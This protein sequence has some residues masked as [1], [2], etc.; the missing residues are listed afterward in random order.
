MK[1][2]GFTIIELL[3]VIFIITILI[4]L[5]IPSISKVKRLTLDLKQKAEF[6]NIE[7]GVATWSH[8]HDLE[9]PESN[10][11]FGNSYATVG[12]QKLAEALL[13]RDLHGFDD[14][15]T[16]NAGQD[17]NDGVAYTGIDY[18]NREIAYLDVDNFHAYQLAQIYDMSIFASGSS[19]YFGN[20]DKEGN[21]TA[22]DMPAPVLTDVYKRVRTTAIDGSTVKVGSPILYFKANTTDVFSDQNI[23]QSVFDYSDNWHIFNI[24]RIDDQEEHPY[25]WT[26]PGG[27]GNTGNPEFYEDLINP[28]VPGNIYPVPYYKDSYVLLSAG[29]DGLYGTRDDIWNISGKR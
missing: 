8:N 3:T 9:Y 26:D 6:H 22:L 2:K 18:H 13:G 7:I 5:L 19:L 10:V 28:N 16:W 27:M 14:K 29:S 25:N 20:Y 24:G 1:K 15:S 11:S 21:A 23:S 4:G 17:E 12:A